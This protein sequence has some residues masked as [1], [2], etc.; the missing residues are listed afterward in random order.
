M[1]SETALEARVLCRAIA[2]LRLL[3][4]LKIEVHFQNLK[5]LILPLSKNVDPSVHRQILQHCPVITT[6]NPPLIDA[7]KDALVNLVLTLREHCPEVRNIKLQEWSFYSKSLFKFLQR[8]E[9]PLESIYV[10]QSRIDW[11]YSE[12]PAFI[13]T[14][15]RHSTTL[16]DFRLSDFPLENLGR[17]TIAM[18]LH[19]CLALQR[20]QIVDL[21]GAAG[22]LGIEDLV[23]EEWACNGLKHLEMRV[24]WGEFKNRVPYH[25]RK[26]D[27]PLQDAPD[28]VETEEDLERWALL[29]RFYRQIGTLNQ[30]EVLSLK[31]T[32]HG[33]NDH[34]YPPP[35]Y[36]YDD[37]R[38]PDRAWF[39]QMF[40]LGD[41]KPNRRAYLTWFSNLH[42][43]RELRRSIHLI[44]PAI[45]MTLGPAEYRGMA[46]HWP[47][48]KVIE[49]IEQQLKKPNVERGDA[50]LSWLL[51]NLPG[52][53][54]RHVVSGSGANRDED[55]VRMRALW[56][57]RKGRDNLDHE[58]GFEMRMSMMLC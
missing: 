36:E 6:L 8:L 21:H 26:I 16:T 22:D 15:T 39:P 38:S 19:Q 43:L 20:F 57:R 55:G 53:D 3:E 50:G 17:K 34:Y 27:K 5:S 33:A 28:L 23:A 49:L 29:E 45:K 51:K 1:R 10:F 30:L 52:I 35:F 32:Y 24:D 40:T 7:N 11:S 14:I 54:V 58:V 46:T 37:W 56:N 9:S 4:H 25:L 47:H 31:A 13:A 12:R 44:S 42:N 18:V 41:N 48:L 2:G